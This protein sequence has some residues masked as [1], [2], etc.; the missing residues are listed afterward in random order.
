MRR[1][2]F[3]AILGAGV[4]SF[5]GGQASAQVRV[6]GSPPPPPPPF[7]PTVILAPPMRL[8]LQPQLDLNVRLLDSPLSIRP[9]IAP[10][11]EPRLEVLPRAQARAV[12]Y[13]PQPRVV[14]R[15]RR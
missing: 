7:V 3:S 11:L 14:A 8:D 2:L 5:G 15:R 6:A 9:D 12:Q 1:F 4:L 13:Y 10:R